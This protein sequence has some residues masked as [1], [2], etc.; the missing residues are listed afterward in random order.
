MRGAPA[1]G[2]ESR[3]PLGKVSFDHPGTRNAWVKA[4]RRV[5]ARLTLWTILW[6]TSSLAPS[7]LQEFDV[8][9]MSDTVE[10]V[11]GL[12]VSLTFFAYLVIL[13]LDV[14]ALRSIKRIRRI[15][16]A[17]PWRPIPAARKHPLLKD[18][19]GVPVQLQLGAAGETDELSGVMSARGSVRRRR[20][21]EAM[22]QGAWYAGDVEGHGVLALP[23]GTQLMEV[24]P[25]P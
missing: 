22:E 3:V 13:Y 18:A 17:A 5:I 24:Q 11:L 15:L 19:S 4:R 21:P 1:E 25:R 14:S 2:R 6:V 10:G 20:W 9:S 8:I 16:E 23:G 12:I 7:L